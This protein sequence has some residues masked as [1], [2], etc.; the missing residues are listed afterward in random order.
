MTRGPLK[1][2]SRFRSF[3]LLITLAGVCLAPAHLAWAGSPPF[4]GEAVAVHPY[5]LPLSF[6]VN[7]GQAD[8]AVKYLARGQ[9]YTLFLTSDAAVLGLRG[10][11]ANSTAW[12]RLVLQ[13][14]S[15][16]PNA[17]GDEPLP[18]K[19]NY[20][21]GNDPS[22]W[23]TNI[24]NFARASFR[25]IYPGVDLVYYGRQGMLEN[26]FELAPGTNPKTIRWRVEGAEQIH[27]DAAGNLVLT[28]GEVNCAFSNRGRTSTTAR[29]CGKCLSVIAF[30]AST[31]A[32]RWGTTTG[33]KS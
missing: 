28:V 20:F 32:L 1:T 10:H 15:P 16:Q 9:G 25:Q 29:R 14:A 27:L 33:S 11:A 5:L 8:P 12:V 13:G 22:R 19:T 2:E 7:Q 30:G 4:P 31:L 18:G 26:D 24:P 21:V 3:F 6:E 23:R 17:R